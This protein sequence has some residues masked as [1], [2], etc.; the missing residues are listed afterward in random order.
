ME[1]MKITIGTSP[2]NLASLS[3]V[4]IPARIT[5]SET[6]MHIQIDPP[7]PPMHSFMANLRREFAKIKSFFSGQSLAIMQCILATEEGKIHRE[8]LKTEIWTENYPANPCVRRAIHRLNTNL[9]KHGF[10]YGVRGNLK[11]TKEIYR[12]VLLEK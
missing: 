1:S 5:F 3:G 2:A 4:A 7:S 8:T 10:G 11:G 9:A 6:S 12:I